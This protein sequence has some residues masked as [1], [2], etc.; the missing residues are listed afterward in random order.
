MGGLVSQRCTQT[1]S[2]AL[3]HVLGGATI[4][5][6]WW[7][8][9]TTRP[10]TNVWR[11]HRHLAWRL[12]RAVLADALRDALLCTL[13]DKTWPSRWTITVAVLSTCLRSA[14]GWCEALS[15]MVAVSRI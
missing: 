5:A 7:L 11:S 3:Q 12:R 2:V 8:V 15:L 14:S 6:T 13:R 4:V 10:P 1:S 9:C